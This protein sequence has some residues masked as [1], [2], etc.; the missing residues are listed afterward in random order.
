LAHGREIA[1]GR[2]GAD[3]GA[4]GAGPDPRSRRRRNVKIGLA[5]AAA[6][7]ATGSIVAALTISTQPGPTIPLLSL[8][9]PKFSLQGLKPSQAAVSS[10]VLRRGGPTVVNFWGSWCPPCVQE[11]PALQEVHHQLGN[12]VRFVG[13]DEEDT[14]SAALRFLHHVGVTYPSGFDGN[15]AVG[16]AFLIAGTPTTY[17]IAHGK[18]L[19]FHTGRMTKKQLLTYV[20]QIFGVS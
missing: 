6:A 19:D 9:V 8:A 16:T 4:S 17:F 14:R 1:V 12:K 10:T 2:R 3:S 15:G 7:V 5:L 11:M 13:I 20:R 18:M